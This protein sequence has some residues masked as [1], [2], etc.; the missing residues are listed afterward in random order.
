[1]RCT[2]RK[3]LSE[4]GLSLHTAFSCPSFPNELAQ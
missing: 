2:L 1:L 3:S 4:H